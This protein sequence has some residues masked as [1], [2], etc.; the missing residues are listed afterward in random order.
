MTKIRTLRNA[1][2]GSDWK[3]AFVKT[4]LGLR[5]DL[6]P[7]AADE[8]SDSEFEARKSLRP[9]IAAQN[10]TIAQGARPAGDESRQA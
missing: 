5:P 3:S 7:D 2:P 4:L 8:I 9:D 6:N 10:W 1:F